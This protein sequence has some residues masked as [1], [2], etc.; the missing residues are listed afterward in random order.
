VTY[1]SQYLETIGFK[2]RGSF[3]GDNSRVKIYCH[4]TRFFGVAMM[5]T[6]DLREEKN[7]AMQLHL[8]TPHHSAYDPDTIFH[9][10]MHGV[11]ERLLG[12]AG[13]IFAPQSCAAMEGICDFFPCLYFGKEDFSSRGV[14][15]HPYND[16]YPDSFES[17]ESFHSVHRQG[18]ILC[19]AL[20][21]MG[22]A[23]GDRDKTLKLM[24]DALK[25]CKENPGYLHIRDCL[26]EAASYD[27][28]ANNLSAY[29]W[30]AFANY[31][32]GE[33]ASGDFSEWVNLREDF[34]VPTQVPSFS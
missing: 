1:F 34:S 31:G 30:G 5:N 9:E 29:I 7:P 8:D 15:S 27:T 17:C 24:L 26:L 19:A 22:R 6:P 14:R 23:I 18:E 2:G 16:Q 11:M 3:K 4:N 12:G 28:D 32:K 20:L 33:R 21:Q 13:Y 10:L 25:I